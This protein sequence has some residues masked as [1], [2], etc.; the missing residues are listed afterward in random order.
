MKKD[1]LRYFKSIEEIRSTRTFPSKAAFYS[2]L[3]Q[4]EVDEQE[5]NDAKHLYESRVAL[6]EN[7]LDKWNDFSDYLRYYNLLDVRPLVEALSICFQKF[8]EYFNVDPGM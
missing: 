8:R 6:S 7:D 4:S 1:L 2:E 5:Y 3:K